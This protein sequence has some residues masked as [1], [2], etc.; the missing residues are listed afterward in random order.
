MIHDGR[1]LVPERRDQKTHPRA[2]ANNVAFSRG[3]SRVAVRCQRT[4]MDGSFQQLRSSDSKNL[5][6]P[7]E[8]SQ[9]VAHLSS[10]ES[11][12]SPYASWGT[13]HDGQKLRCNLT[14]ILHSTGSQEL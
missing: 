6:N 12:V 9:N 10:A 14:M 1:I 13:L 11:R 8:T 5:F 3:L 7:S 2:I 4:P